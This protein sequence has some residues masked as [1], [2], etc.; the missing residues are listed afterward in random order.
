[1][2]F[3]KVNVNSWS[4]EYNLFDLDSREGIYG[5]FVQS[6]YAIRLEVE[7]LVNSHYARVLF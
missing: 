3:F 7:E 6:F 5:K 2:F 4:E 1:M